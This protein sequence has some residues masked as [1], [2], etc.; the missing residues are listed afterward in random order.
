[1]LFHL[2]FVILVAP[3]GRTDFITFQGFRKKNH[4]A[5]N[6]ETIESLF[7]A[8]D[9]IQ[10]CIKLVDSGMIPPAETKYII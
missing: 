7:W 9:C 1:M 2:A 5:S 3:D 10:I 4:K 8:N 6:L